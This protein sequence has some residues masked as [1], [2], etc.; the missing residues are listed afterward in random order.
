MHLSNHRRFYLFASVISNVRPATVTSPLRALLSGFA[1]TVIDRVPE[2]V[3]VPPGTVIQD[4]SVVLLV[5]VHPLVVVTVASAVPPFPGNERG[6]SVTV[7]E[8]PAA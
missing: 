7:N 5:H 3:R 1:A 6:V 8:H 2:P 4:G